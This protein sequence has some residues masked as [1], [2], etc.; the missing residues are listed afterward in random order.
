MSPNRRKG[1]GLETDRKL[2]EFLTDKP[3]LPLY[4]VAD[5]LEWSIGKVQKSLERLSKNGLVRFKRLV[6]AGRA[7]KLA[8]PS[9]LNGAMSAKPFSLASPVAFSIEI[10]F[11]MIELTAWK[12]RANFYGLDRSSIG[13]SAKEV[14]QWKQNSLYSS[15]GSIDRDQGSI[16]V[17]VPHELGRFYLIDETPYSLSASPNGEEVLITIF[18]TWKEHSKSSSMGLSDKNAEVS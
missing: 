2:L 7:M 5:Q 1:S 6:V 4:Q 12:D 18:E 3:G 10:P 14:T 11:D 13:I 17:H 9:A 8:I 16:R 15:T